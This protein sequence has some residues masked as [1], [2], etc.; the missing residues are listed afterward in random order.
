MGNVLDSSNTEMNE[1]PS[2]C[3][4]PQLSVKNSGCKQQN[5]LQLV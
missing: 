3:L 5:P 1:M 2:L 4:E